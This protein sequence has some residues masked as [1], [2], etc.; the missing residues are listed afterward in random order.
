MNGGEEEV[1]SE[2]AHTHDGGVECLD[3]ES[4]VMGG[5]VRSRGR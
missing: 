2:E 4:G 5:H 3:L 1:M